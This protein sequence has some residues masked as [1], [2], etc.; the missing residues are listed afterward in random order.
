[1]YEYIRIWCA[2][3]KTG[4]NANIYYG[5]FHLQIS[6]LF[7]IFFIIFPILGWARFF[8]NIDHFHLL[9]PKHKEDEMN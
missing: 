6:T 2:S 4:E 1:M 7:Y 3:G 9:D 8:Y 5:F